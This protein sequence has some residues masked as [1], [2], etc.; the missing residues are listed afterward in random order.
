MLDD[1]HT[2]I[3]SS[4]DIKTF[5]EVINDEESFVWGDFSKETWN[6]D[7][8]SKGNVKHSIRV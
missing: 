5:D 2:G 3:R 4:K 1:Y 6:V 7:N 8:N